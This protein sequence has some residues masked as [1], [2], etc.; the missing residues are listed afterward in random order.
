M[1]ELFRLIGRIFVDASQALGELGKTEDQALDTTDSFEKL[2][3]SLSN[4]GNFLKTSAFVKAVSDAV[5]YMWN[6]SAGVAEAGRE[7][8]ISAQKMGFSTE[9]YQEWAYVGEMMGIEIGQISSASIELSKKVGEASDD[10]LAALEE[11]GVSVADAM[12]AEPE[13]LFDMVITG[14]QGVESFTRRA[15]LA[16]KLLGG[17]AEDLTPLLDSNA[18]EVDGLKKQYEELGGAMSQELLEKE[19]EYNKAI[20]SLNTAWDGVKNHLA[21]ATLPGMTTIITGLTQ[22]LTG[23]FVGGLKTAANGVTEYLSGLYKAAAEYGYKIADSVAGAFGHDLDAPKDVKTAD[24][25]AV[26]INMV[27][28]LGNLSGT[29]IQSG[30]EGLTR[31]RNDYVAAEQAGDSEAMDKAYADF[32]AVAA[33]FSL[34]VDGMAD[35]FPE[36]VTGASDSAEA[37]GKAASS[38]SAA[39]NALAQVPASINAWANAA[40]TV[41]RWEN[42][43]AI[44]SLVPSHASGIQ[45]VPRDEYPAKLHYGERV[46]TRQEA[47]EYNA[48]SSGQQSAIIINIQSVAQTPA[49]EAAAIT[50]ALQRAR[51]AM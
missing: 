2:T 26:V 45:F 43:G 29:E 27:P 38:A 8:Q 42:G 21:E 20:T 23:D 33:G 17:A 35:V 37:M 5:K 36:L 41:S 46:L 1:F 48:G 11:I 34:D 24:D 19:D 12:T 9:A 22:A 3:K 31:L 51:W 47:A 15:A 39:S 10:T 7:I 50:A 4:F 44:P 28:N 32:T 13:E 18:T 49:E 40:S 16:D 6:L 14:L 25:M 30:V